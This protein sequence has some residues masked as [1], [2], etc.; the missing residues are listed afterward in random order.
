MLGPNGVPLSRRYFSQET[1]KDLDDN[2]MVRGY[3]I[4]KEK[5]VLVTDEELER[6]APEKTRDIDLRRFVDRD[7]IPPIYFE[8]SYFL[9]P[10]RDTQKAYRLLAET[11]ES[12]GRAGIGSFVM[13]GKEYL[14][15]ILSENGIL[16]AETMR[17]ADEL[18]SP[19]EVNLPKKKKVP[20]ASVTRFETLI[21]KKTR[22]SLSAAAMK[23]DQTQRLL[24]LVKKKRS[25]G[26]DVVETGDTGNGDG[27]VVDIMEVLKKSLAKKGD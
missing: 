11:M 19:S 10:G 27:N 18:R 24:K 14:V 15:A 3:E 9:T 12:S 7:A 20:K 23:D 16:R 4:E 25:R 21:K 17:F 1:G 26:K 13:R 6:L 22:T 8:R 5:Y 2:Q